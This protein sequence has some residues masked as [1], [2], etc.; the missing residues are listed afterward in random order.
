M[1]TRFLIFQAKRAFTALGRLQPVT[2]VTY[3]YEQTKAEA[4]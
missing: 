3:I 2:L 4:K 1:L